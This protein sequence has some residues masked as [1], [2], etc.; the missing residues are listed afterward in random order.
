MSD[1]QMYEERNRSSGID[2][3]S[4]AHYLVAATTLWL[5]TQP[6]N[7]D[8]S[9]HAPSNGVGL[10]TPP[11]LKAEFAVFPCLQDFR[12]SRAS[13]SVISGESYAE[14]PF[15]GKRGF[16]VPG[17]RCQAPGLILLMDGVPTSINYR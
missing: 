3:S 9:F 4:H 8:Y 15:S 5:K 12:S 6:L 14:R 16:F 10:T 11:L 2:T 13:S 1:D 7:H 17:C